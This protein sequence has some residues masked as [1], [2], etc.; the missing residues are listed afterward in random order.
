MAFRRK[1]K[2][3]TWFWTDKKAAAMYQNNIKSRH[4]ENQRKW[5]R[6]KASNTALRT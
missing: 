2:I 3:V 6:K 4:K 5:I 1:G